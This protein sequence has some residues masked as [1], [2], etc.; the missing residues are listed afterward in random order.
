MATA[1]AA[2][3]ALG[4][5][6]TL[7]YGVSPREMAA[8]G[9]VPPPYIVRAIPSFLLLIVAEMAVGLAKGRKLYRA[10]DAAV[11]LMQ[12]STQMLLGFWIKGLG[13]GVYCWIHENMR[14][15]RIDDAASWPVWLACLLGVDFGY[16]WLH[17]TAHE[18]HVL[19]SAHSVHH[20]GEDYNLAT[21]LRQGVL[22]PA[23]G[24]V[25]SLHNALFF[26]PTV[27]A[28]HAALNTL[29]QFWIH[30][31]V[32]GSLGPLEYVLNTASHHRMHHRPPGNCNYAGVLI[33]WDV[34]FGTFVPEDEQ[35]D[36][37]GLAK[38]YDTFDPVWANLEHLRRMNATLARSSS[39]GPARW[40]RL[41]TTRRVKH[42]WTFRPLDLFKK[43]PAPV[44]S[45]W[46]A[47]Q[48]NPRRRLDGMPSAKQPVLRGYLAFLFVSATVF[49]VYAMQTAPTLI[50][51]EALLAQVVCLSLFVSVGRLLDGFELGQRVNTTRVLG[52]VCLSSWI[53]S[54]PVADREPTKALVALAF[55]CFS[56]VDALLWSF[57]YLRLWPELHHSKSARVE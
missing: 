7:F 29:Y 50:K 24:W 44:R 11:S 35:K 57:T 6:R 55:E 3:D 30:T 28:H 12:G 51:H 39:P 10:N 32:I 36:Y 8:A 16:Y 9:E 23:Y 49:A 5:L 38:Q 48:P 4:G 33:I 20:S 13:L 31:T 54:L 22:Q 46:D 27:Y 52:F 15:V 14:L 18:F 56:L 21:A 43:R 41:L 47:P 1:A 25:F 53:V 45:L 40:L 26:S 34:I 2:A 17:R 42:K 37:Y 19:W